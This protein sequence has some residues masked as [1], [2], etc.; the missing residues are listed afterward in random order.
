MKPRPAVEIA[1]FALLLASVLVVVYSVA[2]WLS[3]MTRGGVVFRQEI[4]LAGVVGPLSIPVLALAVPA[5][6]VERGA[7]GVTTRAVE[8]LRTMSLMFVLVAAGFAF[9]LVSG[10]FSPRALDF[11]RVWAGIGAGIVV[12]APPA[13]ILFVRHA[14]LVRGVGFA[15]S[16]LVV[17]PLGL[18]GSVP[19]GHW[20]VGRLSG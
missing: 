19:A 14:K 18:A 7:R 9:V 12:L 20:L 6:L 13:G 15:A 1:A 3:A 8:A 17:L 16:F 10:A 2:T 5:F 11:P 4:W